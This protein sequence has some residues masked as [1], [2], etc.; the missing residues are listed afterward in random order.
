MTRQGRRRI[1][2]NLTIPRAN[3]TMAAGRSQI[4]PLP[5]VQGRWTT[6]N[7]G[8]V[9]IS[10]SLSTRGDSGMPEVSSTLCLHAG[11]RHVTP[12][13]LAAVKA[14]PPEGRWY[15]LAHGSVLSRVKQTLG[16]AGYVV[17][18]EQL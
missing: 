4:H 17:R 3:S 2:H 8:F 11:A 7:S 15:P 5:F 16:E 18:R 9:P 13:E 14:P 10:R 6:H 12:E 1:K